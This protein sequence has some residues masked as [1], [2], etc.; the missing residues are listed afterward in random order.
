M[1]R[2]HGTL[3]IHV[4][5]KLPLGAGLGSSAA[6]SV[7][8]AG[9]LSQFRDNLPSSQHDQLELVNS[10]A[11]SAEVLL[12]G[13]PSGVDNAISTFGGVVLYRKPGFQ[14][15]VCQLSSFRFLIVNTKVSR[16]T[17]QQVTTVRYR[18]EGYRELTELKFHV[19]EEIVNNFVASQGQEINESF[20]GAQMERNHEILNELGVGHEVIDQVVEICKSFG[21]WTKITGAG[22]GGC[23]LSL[24]PQTLVESELINLLQQL[25][26]KGFQVYLSSIGG[27]G[28]SIQTVVKE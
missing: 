28:L 24:I 1:Y 7:A 10:F 26:A 25:E 14:R 21:L 16:S 4:S 27:D 15:L 9:A 23:T 5:S 17:K 18:F 11:Y 20:L 19:I 12:H 22:G 6:F 3:R 8:L 2:T 13:T